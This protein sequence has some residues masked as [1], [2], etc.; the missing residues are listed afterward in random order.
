MAL[1]Y[2][3][4]FKALHRDRQNASR[5]NAK[6]ATTKMNKVLKVLKLLR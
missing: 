5:G 2:A 4:L 1:D 3:C 6:R